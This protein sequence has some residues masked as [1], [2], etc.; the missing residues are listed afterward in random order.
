MKISI[1]NFKSIEELIQYELK[2]LTIISGVNST[3][4]SSFIQ[5]LLLL[6]QTIERNSTDE[7]LFLDG[8]LYKVKSFVDILT[9]KKLENKLKLELEFTKNDDLRINSS[10]RISIFDSFSDFNITIKICYD[11]IN[12]KETISEFTIKYLLPEGE[13]REQFLRAVSKNENGKK[14]FS[15]ESNNK[16][17]GKD[18]GGNKPITPDN[19]IY[20][21]IYPWYYEVE[22]TEVED[23]PN[24]ESK[25]ISQ[26]TVDK[27]FFNLDGIKDLIDSTFKAFNYIGP[28]RVEPQDEYLIRDKHNSVGINGEFVA[29]VLEIN[30]QLPIAYFRPNFSEDGEVEFTRVE[31]TLLGAVKYWMCDVFKIGRDLFVQKITDVYV[32]YLVGENGIKTTIKHV[33]FGISQ[34]LPIVVEGLL[35]SNNS[36]LILEQPEIHL[37]PKIQSLLFD[38]LNSLTLQGKKIII[39]THS[40]HFI[41]RMRRRVAEDMQD[42]MAEKIN[43]TFIETM[44]GKILFRSIDVDDLGTIEYFPENFID[45][46]GSELKAI[47]NAQI[48]KQLR[49]NEV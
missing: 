19:I 43:L 45:Q 28:V 27:N 22:R 32:I 24:K 48:K 8:D 33:G 36:T 47:L 14:E 39:E 26:F 29:Q 21:S 10:K 2:P 30:S 1:Y 20:S 46:A 7:Q 35:M 11:F 15:I 40:D 13:K 12:G 34:I 18:F 25:K 17:F 44:K 42:V 5:I 3:G 37:H 23:S 9:G 16:L 4:K 41:T 6:K 38:F 31:S 49:K